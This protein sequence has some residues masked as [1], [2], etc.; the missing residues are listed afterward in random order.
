MSSPVLIGDF[1]HRI[2]RPID[3]KADS[4]H[5]LV[6]IKMKHKGVVLRQ[7]KLGAEIKSK[8]YQVKAG[9]FILS[10][11][12]ARNGAFGIVP[13][14]LDG[15][16]VTNDFWYFDI[17]EKIVDKHFF[18]ELTSTKWF[19]EICRKGSD[20]TTQRIRLQ[21]NKFFNQTVFLPSLEEQR[22][23]I[24]HFQRV[25]TKDGQIKSELTH[26]QILLKKLRQQILQEAIEGKLTAD[27]RKQNIDVEP[28]SELLE[29]IAAE[30][31]QLI[32][33]KKIKKQKPL[34][35]ISEEEKSFELP[36]GWEWCRL[37]S[38]TYGF[39]YGT[40]SKSL[41]FGDV[42]VLRM[43]NIQN[44]ELDWKDLVY[45]SD[46]DEINKFSLNEGDLLFNRTNSR[47]LVGKTG[48]YRG[49]RK[50]IYAGYLVRFNMAGSV[51][52]DFANFVLNS[53]L[54]CQWCSEVKT[55][56]LG[57]SNINA[58]KLSQFRF[59][60]P[61]LVE[62]KAIV[63][64]V[65]KSLILC[66]Q[67]ETQITQNQAHAEQLMQAVLKE[68]FQSESATKSDQPKT[69]KPA[70]TQNR[71]NVIPLKPTRADY[72]KRTLLAAEIVHQL[73]KQP[74]L[75]H[76]KL[77]KL[78][79]LCQKT[80]QMQLPT[81]FLQQAA[82]P[83]DPKMARSLDKQLKD[84]KWF[85]YQRE[86]RL[87]YAPLGNAGEHRADF[88]KY[89]AQQKEGIQTL[90]D[91]FREEKSDQMEIVA[92][93]YACWERLL[94]EKADISDELLFKR[95]YQWSEEKSKYPPKRLKTAIKWMSEQ[96]IV[97]QRTDNTCRGTE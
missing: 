49:E 45:S 40:S 44:G 83:Y 16:V 14:E 29:R 87:K 37:G 93:L 60:L 67:L 92:T 50:S 68:A 21:K 8:M 10:G 18:L 17:D 30:K 74:T 88:D 12:D 57:Q 69:N 42:P 48:L 78:I 4:K 77:Q 96:G 86:E 94:H 36:E 25:K 66:D 54:H 76:L 58:T 47:E 80:E 9:D 79:Y 71:D 43:G 33:D 53:R 22:I 89:F 70:K 51:L 65:D 82:G 11:I 27:W 13:P 5:K 59:P 28:A 2:K 31:A 85:L 23:F 90:I 73:H 26:Q 75:G 56:A 24:E 72:Y 61:S 63:A 52:P 32:E 15:A 41:K 19:D 20:G 3:L 46:E 34:P 95:F 84:K 35:P 81:N 1:L 39:Q 38:L 91:L 6:T 62:Q 64:K 55:D 97:P 7:E